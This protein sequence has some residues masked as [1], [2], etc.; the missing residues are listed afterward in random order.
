VVRAHA[1]T[2]VVDRV[3]AGTT[4]AVE[5]SGALLALDD[6]EIGIAAPQGVP[7]S[8]HRAR[9]SDGRFEVAVPLTRSVFGPIRP[10]AAGRY[11]I[12]ARRPG[13]RP[14]SREAALILG[15]GAAA[16]LPAT[17]LGDTI[18]TT[19]SGSAGAPITVEVAAPI[20]DDVLRRSAQTQLI[21][22]WADG[23]RSIEDAVFFCVD[24]GSNAGDSALAIHQELRR[25]GTSLQL[26]WGVDDLSVPVPE[27]GIPVLKLSPAWYEKLNTSRYIVNNYGGIWGLAKHPDQRYLQ[28]WHG[29][30]L[31]LI[32]ASEARRRKGPS[33]GLHTIARESA[34]W[35]AFISPSPYMTSLIRTEF[36]FGG[37]VL[38]IG[39]PRND[40][41]ATFTTEERA[42]I[43][44]GLGLPPAAKVLLYAPT[45][46]E[47]QRSGWKAALYEGLPLSRLLDLLGPEW[48]V[49]LRGHSFNARADRRDRSHGRVVDVTHH[50]DIN[51]LYIASDV[52]L[53]DYSSVMFDYAVTRRP[54]LFFA[55]DLDRYEATRGVYFDLREV[56]PGP[57]YRAVTDLA[58]G[59]RD[60]D[61]VT[62]EYA[63]RYAAFRERFAP[64]DDG[65]AASRA[66]DAFFS[67][68]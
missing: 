26:Y 35:D 50:P 62:T 32:G 19:V 16:T 61:A 68:V 66:V 5:L 17:F 11:E 12:R 15:S 30:P 40:R 29:T 25:R 28:T 54:I 48:Y 13:D 55:P 4:E 9:V 41:L 1:R 67:G 10:L 18:K 23:P 8:W 56:S 33:S 7:G 24:L 65:K 27:G 46:R 52:L 38:E 21:A 53:T 58:A 3:S 39:Y 64:W 20:A 43:R 44:A 14:G 42:A 60:L 22:Q 49:L 59:L 47:H 6:I 2:A 36:S 31:K 34:E 57:I 45:F 63:G 37:D 51:D